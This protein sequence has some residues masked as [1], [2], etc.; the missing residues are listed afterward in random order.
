MPMQSVLEM[1]QIYLWV[2]YVK[3]QK[4][5]LPKG[6]F[7]TLSKIYNGVYI[8]SQ[9]INKEKKTVTNIWQEPKY[10]SAT[11]SFNK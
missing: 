2:I 7:R 11:L 1:K 3:T 10:A 4:W 8:F 9:K 6:M 5:Q